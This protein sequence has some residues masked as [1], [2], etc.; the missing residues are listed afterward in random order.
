MPSVGD[1]AQDGNAERVLKVCQTNRDLVLALLR[2]VGAYFHIDDPGVFAFALAVSVSTFLDGDPLWGMIVG[3]ASGGK[4]EVL[5][6]LELIAARAVDTLTAAALLHWHKLKPG[7]APTRRGILVDIG[8]RGLVTIGDF[9]T[10][11]QG[12]PHGREENVLPP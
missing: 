10:V 6:I 5:R 3:A 11:L 12:S 8:E 7:S 1:D 9:S 2:S 4:T